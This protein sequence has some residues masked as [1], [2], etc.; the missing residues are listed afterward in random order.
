MARFYLRLLP[1]HT[2]GVRRRRYG[3]S[4]AAT[5]GHEYLVVT[6]GTGAGDLP[7]RPA[8][9]PVLCEYDRMAIPTPQ[10]EAVDEAGAIEADVEAERIR[11]EPPQ[12]TATGEETTTT[13]RRRP[14]PTKHSGFAY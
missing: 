5:T 2:R 12:N 10:R 13:R 8:V 14:P 6:V 3:A 7:R 4:D 1:P 9:G 11:P